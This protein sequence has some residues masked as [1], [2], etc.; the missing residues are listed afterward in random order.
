MDSTSADVPAAV[1]VV[2]ASSVDV[3]DVVDARVVDVPA[4]VPTSVDVPADVRAPSCPSGMV[5]I[6]AGSFIMGDAD[7]E[8]AYAQPPHMVTL[9]A[10]CLDLTEVTVAAW[11]GC[12]AAGCTAPDTGSMC[13]WS[14]S[15]G[16]RESHPINCVSWSQARSYCLSRGGDL[17]TEAQWEYAARGPDA[18]NHIFPWG[19]ATPAAQLCWSGGGTTRT[20]TCAVQSFP[21]GNSPFGI[22][23]MAGNVA[24]WMLDWAAPYSAAAATDPSG[25]I[26][27][28]YRSYRGGAWNLSAPTSVRVPYR[29]ADDPLFRF[30]WFGFRCARG[31]S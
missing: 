14:T 15:P 23:D 4:D 28:E 16:A 3:V 24:E 13:N 27:G 5:L 19:N 22:F 29:I 9:S 30:G 26:V 12:T 1:D 18:T 10:F 6:P 25:P 7:A 21:A 20:S 31:A 2:D 11:R 17:P 8:S